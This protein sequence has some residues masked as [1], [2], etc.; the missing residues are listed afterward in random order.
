MKVNALPI[1]KGYLMNCQ[2]H[3]TTIVD[4]EVESVGDGSQQS[5]KVVQGQLGSKGWPP[6]QVKR[7]RGRSQEDGGRAQVQRQEKKEQKLSEVMSWGS[8]MLINLD[9]PC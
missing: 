8:I 7:H 9:A 5:F 6:G 2:M 3:C 1:A 4:T